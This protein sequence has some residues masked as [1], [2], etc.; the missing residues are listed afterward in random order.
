MFVDVWKQSITQHNATQM[1]FGVHVHGAITCMS[2][3]IAYDGGENHGTQLSHQQAAAATQQAAAAANI[4][5]ADVHIRSMTSDDISY[6]QYG[7]S[8]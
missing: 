7:N 4:S 1:H 3:M 2:H 8:M 5:A 6:I